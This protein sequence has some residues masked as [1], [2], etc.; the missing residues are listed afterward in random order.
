MSHSTINKVLMSVDSLILHLSFLRLFVMVILMQRENKQGQ[1]HILQETYF[2]V[3]N[4][5]PSNTV[6]L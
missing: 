6:T 5:S 2:K 3:F 1:A 4:T